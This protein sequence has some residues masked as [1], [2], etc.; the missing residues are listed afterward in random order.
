MSP[1]AKRRVSAFREGELAAKERID[2]IERGERFS[3]KGT[4]AQRKRGREFLEGERPREPCGGQVLSGG[5]VSPRA[6]R[7][8]SAESRRNKE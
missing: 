3:H 2:R 8:V 7:R 5:P 1:R 4:E 6:K